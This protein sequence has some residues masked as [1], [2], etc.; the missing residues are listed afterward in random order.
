M[1]MTSRG[2][3]TIPKHIRE[4]EGML[5]GSEVEFV[6]EDGRLYLQKTSVQRCGWEATRQVTGKSNVTMTTDEIMAMTRGED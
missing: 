4:L 3:V 2:R 1:K 6:F 5:P